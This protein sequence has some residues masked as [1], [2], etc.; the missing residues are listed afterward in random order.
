MAL[1]FLYITQDPFINNSE[2]F[3]RIL[4]A[5]LIYSI[6]PGNVYGGWGIL[7]DPNGNIVTYMNGIIAN[8]F[9][10]ATAYPYAYSFDFSSGQIIIVPPGWTFRAFSRAIAVQGSLEEVLMVH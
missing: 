1:K 6:G 4:A 5:E 2:E 9:T 7:E 3:V 8:D 10:E